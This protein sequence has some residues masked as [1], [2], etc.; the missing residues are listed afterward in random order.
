M[1][2][3]QRYSCRE[4]WLSRSHVLSV[5]VVRDITKVKVE[6]GGC[7]P[8][9]VGSVSCAIAVVEVGLRYYSKKLVN[10]KF[11]TITYKS[12]SIYKYFYNIILFYLGCLSFQCRIVM[13]Q[14]IFFK[15]LTFS[16]MSCYAVLR[17]HIALLSCF[18]AICKWSKEIFGNICVI[19]LKN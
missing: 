4:W 10:S 18:D 12:R 11:F 3:R 17:Y 16:L 5:P 19:T 8:G 9:G 2:G 6:N 14:F 15:F 13:L 1:A 7:R